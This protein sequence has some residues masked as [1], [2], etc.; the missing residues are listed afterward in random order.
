MRWST[1]LMHMLNPGQTPV[2]EMG[3]EAIDWLEAQNEV[4]SGRDHR[5]KSH[6]QHMYAIT[7]LHCMT[8]MTVV[9]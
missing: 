6:A 4:N 9:L 7:L 2:S 5:C 3:L 8:C 1:N